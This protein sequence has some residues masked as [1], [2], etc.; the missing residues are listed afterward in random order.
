MKHESESFYWNTILM[1]AQSFVI[2]SIYIW[3][4]RCFFGLPC[5]Y[6]T[7]RGRSVMRWC[8]VSTCLEREWFQIQISLLIFHCA[9]MKQES[10]G[11]IMQMTTWCFSAGRETC[12]EYSLIFHIDWLTQM[13]WRRAPKLLKNKLVVIS[14][15]ISFALLART[16]VAF[17]T[18]LCDWAKFLLVYVFFF[19]YDFIV[20]KEH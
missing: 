7:S 2:I 17:N 10:R 19:R 1:W 14:R 4:A 6:D 16:R 11:R 15:V 18:I 9:I 5:P 13:C 12:Y 20:F 8:Y 3:I